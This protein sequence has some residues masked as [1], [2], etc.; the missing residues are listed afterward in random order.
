VPEEP[1]LLHNRDYVGWLV[2]E[3]LSTLGTSLS[4]F[5]YPLLILFATGSAAKTGIVAAAANV[6]SL[7]TLLIGGVLADRWSRRTI[8]IV[9]RLVEMVVVSTVAVAV[10]AGH[11]VLVHVAAAGLVEGAVVGITSGADRAALRRLVPSGDFARAASQQYGRDMGVRVVGPPLGGVL[12]SAARAVPF[13][14][15]AVS[16]LAAVAGV[17][18]IRRP[19]GPDRKADV[20]REPLLRSAIGGLHYVARHPYLRFVAC[21][22]AAVNM[23]GSGLSLLVILLV[24]A[25]GGGA[26][27][28]GGTQAIAAVG[29]LI[30]AFASGWI[31]R[32]LPGRR[33]AIALS[34]CITAAA[35]GMAVVGTP[36]AIGAMMA[37]VSLV[38]VPLNVVFET[39]EMQIIPDAMLGRVSTAVD[40]G[41][42][43][44]RWVAPLAIGL[45]VD[46]TSAATAALVWGI[47]F[48][49]IAVIVQVN[50]SLHLL[51][52]SVE[53]VAG[54]SAT[55]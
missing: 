17:L 20:E 47:A 29:G 42:N 30:G 39:Y 45:I 23:L 32:R 14:G 27:A 12:F 3:S 10:L 35:F 26:Q 16:Y 43:G 15:D 1:G 33:L 5:A 24:R 6:G 51:D 11:V 34:W 9:G 41:A 52:Q 31:I 19:L 49:L 48:A 28:I 25:S 2:G 38:A 21:W 44:L 7:L 22:A 53:Q 13:I 55:L 46:A 40:L 37:V 18:A 4:T 50:R 8:L 54:E 36:W